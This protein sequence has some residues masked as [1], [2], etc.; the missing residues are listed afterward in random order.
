M[1]EAHKEI[2]TTESLDIVTFNMVEG[3][4]SVL[5]TQPHNMI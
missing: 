2:M 5:L 3:S 1:Q 4:N